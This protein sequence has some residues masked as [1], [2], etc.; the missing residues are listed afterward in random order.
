[1]LPAVHFLNFLFGLL[2]PWYIKPGREASVE[3]NAAVDKERES[4][5]LLQGEFAMCFCSLSL[6]LFLGL[7]TSNPFDDSIYI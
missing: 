3:S 1:M 4:L 7:T 5:V 6:S 2:R